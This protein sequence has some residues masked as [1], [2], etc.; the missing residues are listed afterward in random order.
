VLIATG[1]APCVSGLNL[2][3]GGIRYNHVQGI[4]VNDQLETT[5]PNIFAVGDV[6]SQFKF[7]HMADAMARLVVRNALFFGADRA[8][9]LVIPW[10]TF[11]YPEIAHVGPYESDMKENNIKFDVYKVSFEEN[12]RAILE[13]NDIGFV[14][15]FVVQGTDKVLAGTICGEGA[16]NMISEIT[17]LITQNI[18]LMKMAGVIHPYP[19]MA[20]GVRRTGDLFN[21]TR[22]TT[23]VKVLFRK[24][25]AARR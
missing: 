24:L 5:N 9:Q 10:C 4:R 20:D 22:L 17:L 25:L 16:G 19:T 15:I 13:G 11:T 1:R 7:T 14:K 12:D 2:E 8:S 23:F 3:S 6:C 18:G 21:R